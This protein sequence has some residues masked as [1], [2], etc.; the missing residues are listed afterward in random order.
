MSAHAILW[1]GS[2]LAAWTIQA[3]CEADSMKNPR[4]SKVET[5]HDLLVNE[6][7]ISPI[8]IFD[9]PSKVVAADA[10]SNTEK[11]EILA[12]WEAD[13]IALQTATD[14]GMS[15]GNRPR[16][17][18]VKSAQTMLGA[19]KSTISAAGTNITYIEVFEV[20]PQMADTLTTALEELAKQSKL[21][22]AGYISTSIHK[23]EDGRTVVNYSQWSSK[24][25][26]D[27]MV[28]DPKNH[29]LYTSIKG[30]AKSSNREIYEVVFSE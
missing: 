28:A 16:L 14:E 5:A 12:Q 4:K 1:C 15:G 30:L 6:A 29:S 10:L 23:S 8:A 26:I 13:A 2:L 11:S 9:D 24:R 20:E 21:Q 18:E 7:K 17:D 3:I 19:N 25:D 27:A 22:N